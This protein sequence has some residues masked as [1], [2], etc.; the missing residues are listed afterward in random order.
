MENTKS[1]AYHVIVKAQ[2]KEGELNQ[3]G[4]EKNDTRNR[5][6]GRRMVIQSKLGLV[7]SRD[8]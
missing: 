4:S 6:T 7:R 1:R 8:A 2:K 5:D 3:D